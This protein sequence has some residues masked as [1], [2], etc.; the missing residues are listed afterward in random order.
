[1]NFLTVL[2]I[3]SRI[4]AGIIF[5]GFFVG[6][7][8]HDNHKIFEKIWLYSGFVTMGVG[9]SHLLIYAVLGGV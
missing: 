8:F 6:L 9:L 1:M 5:V 3:I 7:F 2:E 4:V